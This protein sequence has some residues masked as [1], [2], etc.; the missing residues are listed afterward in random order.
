MAIKFALVVAVLIPF[1]FRW[2]WVFKT[3]R[4]RKKINLELLD[5]ARDFRRDNLARIAKSYPHLKLILVSRK[6][7][8]FL[9]PLGIIILIFAILSLKVQ[10][11][12]GII[13]GLM[14]V[15]GVIL[16]NWWASSQELL[17]LKDQLKSLKDKGLYFVVAYQ[18]ALDS[19]P[20][21]LWLR[22]VK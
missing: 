2:L 18:I 15:D 11:L 19:Y 7:G 17:L 4:L 6:M 16:L 10:P 8:E 5:K 20:R 1:V 3:N 22:K 13:L 14:F 12:L 9:I 21:S